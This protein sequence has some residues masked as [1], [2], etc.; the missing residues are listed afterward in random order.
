MCAPIMHVGNAGY[1]AG[2]TVTVS[3]RRS[4]EEGE[5]VEYTHRDRHRKVVRSLG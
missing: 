3:S 4:M 5:K 1:S 2:D